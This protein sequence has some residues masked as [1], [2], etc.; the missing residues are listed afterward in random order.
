MGRTSWQPQMHTLLASPSTG[1]LRAPG[2]DSRFRETGIHR[3]NDSDDTDGREG[4]GRPAE[5]LACF[6][7]VKGGE[8]GQ[9]VKATASFHPWPLLVGGEGAQPTSSL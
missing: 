4:Q 7:A 1:S 5:S 2:Q 3:L 9:E 8:Q 6:S